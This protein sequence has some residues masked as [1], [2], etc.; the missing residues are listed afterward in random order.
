MD[1]LTSN[2]KSIRMDKNISQ[3]ELSDKTGISVRCIKYY[4]TLRRMPSVINAYRL[5]ATLDTTIQDLFPYMENEE[6]DETFYS[7]RT[8]TEY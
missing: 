5:S 6:N 2:L 7:N 8:G 3:Q 1:M 4:E